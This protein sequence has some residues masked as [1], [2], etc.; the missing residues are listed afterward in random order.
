MTTKFGNM[1]PDRKHI[2]LMR[3]LA[4]RQI[5]PWSRIGLYQRFKVC[6]RKASRRCYNQPRRFATE[7]LV[8]QLSL[9]LVVVAQREIN[10]APT[11]RMFIEYSKTKNLFSQPTT[12][13][14]L[15]AMTY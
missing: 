7:H 3:R 13:I 1:Y 5:E 2:V 15:L 6:E 9:V 10:Q 14:S 8:F 4:D 12:G 11:E